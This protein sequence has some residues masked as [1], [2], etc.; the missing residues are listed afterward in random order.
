MCI[1]ASVVQA[2]HWNGYL[3][4]L[5]IVNISAGHYTGILINCSMKSTP[6]I[7]NTIILLITFFCG[8]EVAMK[9]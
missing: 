7:E 3:S 8:L 9:P 4:R 1:S 5:G 2:S 6:L